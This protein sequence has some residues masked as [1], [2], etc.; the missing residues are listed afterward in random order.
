[1]DWIA[2]ILYCIQI[3]TIL[4]QIH[5]SRLMKKLWVQF[6]SRASIDLNLLIFD[7]IPLV[8][9]WM[10]SSKKIE[11][12]ISLTFFLL[13]MVI[14][15]VIVTNISRKA[16]YL[17]LSVAN[18]RREEKRL[19][20]LICKSKHWATEDWKKKK[21][22]TKKVIFRFLQ[23]QQGKRKTKRLLKRLWQDRFK[24]IIL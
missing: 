22:K 7:G 4:S 2:S 8:S 19:E 13:V 21:E 16:I 3:S 20:S 6:S 18:C 23:L 12:S 1:M 11:V 15:L 10:I 14:Y 5:L 9:C 24:F 17:L